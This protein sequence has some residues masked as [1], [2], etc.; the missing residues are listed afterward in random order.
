MAP[1]SHRKQGFLEE[2][3]STGKIRRY[4]AETVLG[5]QSLAEH[6]WGTVILLIHFWP[7]SRPEVIR[8][9][10]IHD[11]GELWSGDVPA[12]TKWKF[13]VLA[14]IV[15]GIEQDCLKHFG[16][17]IKGLTEEEEAQLS[18]C[19]LLELMTFVVHERRSGRC[20]VRIKPFNELLELVKERS[21]RA[22]SEAP[23]RYALELAETH[24]FLGG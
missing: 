4:H 14:D 5:P 11:I 18:V 2:L 23:W 17:E 13:P 19:D 10:L 24:A 8:A 12:P 16:M 15:E 20:A 21:K 6:S 3:L 9:A 22:G 1:K 7:E